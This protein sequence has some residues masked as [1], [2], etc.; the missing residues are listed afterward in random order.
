VGDICGDVKNE[1]I[2]IDHNL[3]APDTLIT[4]EYTESGYQELDN[5]EVSANYM[6]IGDV[7]GD[8]KGEVVLL[9]SDKIIIYKYV[10]SGYQELD[11]KEHY[12]DTFVQ[13]EIGDINNNGKDEIVL[14]YKPI[15]VSCRVIAYEYTESACQKLDGVGY[16]TYATGMK[17][18]D[19]DNDGKDEIMLL[20]GEYDNIVVYEYTG[21]EYK[22]LREFKEGAEGSTIS[23]A[24][25][26]TTNSSYNNIVIANQESVSSQHFE[27]FS[28]SELYWE[29]YLF[30]RFRNFFY[31]HDKGLKISHKLIEIGSECSAFENELDARYPNGLPEDYPTEAI[32]AYIDRLN[33][34]LNISKN[35][36]ITIPYTSKNGEN[37]CDLKLGTISKHEEGALFIKEQLDKNEKEIMIKGYGVVGA[38]G[39]V[40]VAKFA[41]AVATSG[42]SVISEVILSTAAGVVMSATDTIVK[43]TK[44]SAH[45]AMADTA[46][47]SY[48]ALPDEIDDTTKLYSDSLDYILDP[49]AD[50][51]IRI[52]GV[53]MPNIILEG[54]GD[55]GYAEGS[56]T[57]EN[58]GDE[59]INANVFIDIYGPPWKSM[60]EKPIISIA[61]GESIITVP[62]GETIEIPFK[63]SIHLL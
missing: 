62:S 57:V 36:E 47:L 52:V 9:T 32:L 4:Y 12:V 23:I 26:D 41:F 19:V 61:S 18:G 3:I 24:I 5:R 45:E 38:L 20:E 8:G 2:S 1:I 27:P 42:G 43:A 25:G 22:T 55:I 21:S 59:S 7:D 16:G 13:M 31:D 46:I 48:I 37:P 6:E 49:S 51:A 63:V 15:G 40:G 29:S 53:S 14:Y 35:S 56:V 44:V 33:N 11:N 60:L 28:E 58:T 30:D 54:Y 10:G 50:S 34:D 39:T 17:I